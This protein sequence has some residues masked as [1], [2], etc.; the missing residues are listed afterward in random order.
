MS[1][2]KWRTQFDR[3]R[4]KTNVGTSEHILYSPEFDS[5][6][7]FDLVES[8]R[9]DLY[10]YIQSFKDSVDVNMILKRYTEGDVS[11]L[12]RAQG[13]FGDFTQ[14]PGTYAEM[15]NK[16]ND[17]EN[18]FNSLPLETRAKFDHSFGVFVSSF[19]TPEFYDRLGLKP[20]DIKPE[21]VPEPTGGEKVE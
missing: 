8:G 14:F 10:A 5:N 3:K 18:Y 7:H 13:S 2:R 1:D 20:D 17:G 16:L 4:I 15:L 12:S 21:L 19:G 6:G 9:E 11:A